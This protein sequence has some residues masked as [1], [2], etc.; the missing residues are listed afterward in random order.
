VGWRTAREMTLLKVTSMRNMFRTLFFSL[1]LLA[2]GSTAGAQQ[3]PLPPLIRII[4]PFAAG[5]STDVA[6]RAVASELAKR[7]G[8]NVIVENLAGAST[9]IG[10]AAVA[11]GPKDGSIL[12]MTSSSTFT[13]AATKRTVP[14]DVNADLLPVALL[15]EGPLIIAASAQNDIRTPADLVAAARAKPDVITHGTGG[16]GTLAHIAAEMINDSANIQLKHIP[17]KGA[18]LAIGDFVA[19]RIDLMIGVYTTIAPQVKAGRARLVAVTTL[20]PHPAFPGVPPMAS[21]APGFSVDI[22]VGFFVPP[23]TPPALVQ[24]LN[25]ELN[26]VA[27]SKAVREVIEPDGSAP[28]SLSADEFGSLVRDSYAAWKKL[29]TAKNMV[30]D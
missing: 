23:G 13:A 14:I 30:V 19:G 6:A 7:V 18:S 2:M 29:A 28:R 24:R 9:F 15:S 27:K 25:R 10:A 22:W 1:A 12:L 26:E 17:Y 3:V 4:V 5:A 21:A 16:I 8:S 11:K 20:Q